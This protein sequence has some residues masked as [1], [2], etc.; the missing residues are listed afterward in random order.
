[1]NGRLAT[2]P[3]ANYKSDAGFLLPV[4]SRQG[5]LFKSRERDNKQ[6][7]TWV[8]PRESPLVPTD[9]GDFNL[10]YSIIEFRFSI[11][12]YRISIGDLYVT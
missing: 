7:L 4:A 9:G 8:A 12:Q 2:K 10:R 1:M 6:A 5:I 3:L 11:V